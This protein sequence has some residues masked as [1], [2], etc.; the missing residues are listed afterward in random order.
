[1]TYS[2]R[3][4]NHAFQLRIN[5]TFPIHLIVLEVALSPGAQQP[6]PGQA[7]QFP[8]DGVIVLPQFPHQPL[9][10][11]FLIGI[12]QEKSE[13]FHPDPGSNQFFEHSNL[14]IFYPNG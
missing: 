3:F 13:Q 6:D 7:V 12:G 10:V 4:E 8:A 1:L 14:Y 11:I 9:E 5:G 2:G